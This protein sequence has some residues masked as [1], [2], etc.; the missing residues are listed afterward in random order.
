[1]GDG[2]ITCGDTLVKVWDL[3]GQFCVQT[4]TGHRGTVGCLD[5]SFLRPPR[6]SRSG[7]EDEKRQWRLVTGCAD[8]QVRVWSLDNV[9]SEAESTMKSGESSEGNGKTQMNEDNVFRY[10]GSLQP[11]ATLNMNLSNNEGVASI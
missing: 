8:G 5:F 9:K 2:L 11:P 10:I 3:N 4:L 1:M 6:G 7:R